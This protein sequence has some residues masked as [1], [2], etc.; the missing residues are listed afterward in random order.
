MKSI[1][2]KYTPYFSTVLVVLSLLFLPTVKEDLI[3][4]SPKVIGISP[5]SLKKNHLIF[6][7]IP[8]CSHCRKAALKLKTQFEK[9]SNII[10][11]TADN[12]QSDLQ[13]FKDSLTINFPIVTI[14]RPHLRKYFKKAPQFVYVKEGIITA[15]LDSIYLN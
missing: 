13:E 9:D 14:E 3:G 5:D 1:H 10:G 4:K 8:T 7:F 11:L 6:V 15:V 2:Q 12:F